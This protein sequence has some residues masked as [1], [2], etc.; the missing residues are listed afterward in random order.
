[1][2]EVSSTAELVERLLA[3]N[4]RGRFDCTYSRVQLMREYLR[5]AAVWGRKLGCPDEWPFFDIAAH[6]DPTVRAADSDVRRLEDHFSGTP[7]WPTVRRT[8]IWALHW[9]ELKRREG[10]ALPELDYPFE[11]LIAMY[12]RGGGFTT[13][14]GEIE[15]DT[16]SIRRG[17]WRDHLSPEHVVEVDPE[18]LDGLDAIER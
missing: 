9:E 7:V 17:T 10:D 4:W 14:H 5:R 11:P 3:V 2:T 18:T 8:C 1:M 12:E 13:A 15:I 16:A 6:I